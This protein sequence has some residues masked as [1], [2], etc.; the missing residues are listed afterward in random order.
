MLV[1]MREYDPAALN[2]PLAAVRAQTAVVLRPALLSE[3]AVSAVIRAAAGGEAGDELCAT[4]YTACGGNPLYLAEL[5]R[6]ADLSGR[7]WPRCR[8]RSCWQE[9]WRRSR[10]R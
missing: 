1:A 5:L 6:T 3:Q 8:R 7:P 9:G 4:V 10:D 2:A